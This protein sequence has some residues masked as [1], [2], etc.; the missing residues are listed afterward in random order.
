MARTPKQLYKGTATKVIVHEEGIAAFL[1][2]NKPVRDMLV[3]TAQ[4]VADEAQRTASSAEEGPGGR[5]D[6]YSA[7]GFSVQ[8]EARGGK[9]PR[10]N[11]SSNAE[12]E[13][14]LAA[15]FHSQLRDGVG[16]LRAALYKIAPGTHKIFTGKYKR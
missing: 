14:F 1:Q 8:W 4:A 15:H 5:I 12:K 13:T 2:M 11:I 10:V 9:R 3:H 7:A 6:G 16:H